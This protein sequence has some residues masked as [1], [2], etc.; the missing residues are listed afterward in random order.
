MS[1][2]VSML[3]NLKDALISGKY[4]P[5]DHCKLGPY[6]CEDCAEHERN[7]YAEPLPPRPADFKGDIPL[8]FNCP[9][10]EYDE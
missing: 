3:D 4:D 6:Y 2:I 1:W 10:G 5:Y 7:R 8:H 9:P